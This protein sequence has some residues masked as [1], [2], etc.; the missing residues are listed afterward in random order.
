L[1]IIKINRRSAIL[2]QITIKKA[3]FNGSF[4]YLPIL[5]FKMI[6]T[7][8]CESLAQ[9]AMESLAGE[10]LFLWQIAERPKEAAA[11]AQ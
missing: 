5:L 11:N 6:D 4:F 1:N 3:I 8:N 2:K 10:K 7:K 9:T